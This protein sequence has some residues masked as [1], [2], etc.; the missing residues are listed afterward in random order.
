VVGRIRPGSRKAEVTADADNSP[1]EQATRKRLVLIEPVSARLEMG[2]LFTI[3][4]YG[5]ELLVGPYREGPSF[6]WLPH[7]LD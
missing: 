7:G 2:G 3:I 4:G 5:Q 1:V 6:R